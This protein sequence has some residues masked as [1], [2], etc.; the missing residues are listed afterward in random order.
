MN[1]SYVQTYL[2]CFNWFRDFRTSL[3]KDV[4]VFCQLDYWVREF[5]YDIFVAMFQLIYFHFVAILKIRLYDIRYPIYIQ[6][7]YVMY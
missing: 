1:T 3:K 6:I 4:A 7:S 5:V 2:E